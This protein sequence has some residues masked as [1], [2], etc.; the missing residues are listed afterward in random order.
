MG[1]NINDK[2]NTHD[3]IKLRMSA[4]NRSYEGDVIIKATVKTNR[5]EVI[6]YI[7]AFRKRVKHGPAQIETKKTY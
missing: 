7:F 5:R 6:H 3:E 2:N 1:V 4:V